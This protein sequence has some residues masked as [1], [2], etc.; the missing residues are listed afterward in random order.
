MEDIQCYLL[1]RKICF[2]KIEFDIRLEV[3]KLFDC[4]ARQFNKAN[5]RERRY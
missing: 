1:Q 2:L 3:G 5:I 4:Y